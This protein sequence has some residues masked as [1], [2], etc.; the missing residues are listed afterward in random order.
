MLANA[1]FISLGVTLGIITAPLVV[2]VAFGIMS[3]VLRFLAFL[4]GIEAPKK[5]KK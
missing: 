1:F 2:F 4:L 3:L 5:S